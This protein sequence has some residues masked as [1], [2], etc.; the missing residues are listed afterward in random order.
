M[1]TSAAGASRRAALL[2]VPVLIAVACSSPRADE[3]ESAG[4][5]TDVATSA[6][7]PAAETAPSPDAVLVS[8][9]EEGLPFARFLEQAESRRR[10]WRENYEQGA[11]SAD[12]IARARALPGGLRLLVVAEDWCG[13]SA[14]TIPYLARLAEEAPGLDLRVIDSSVGRSMMEARPTPDGR[15]ATPTVV[16]LDE[17]GREV[18]CWV[19]RPAVL[20]EWFLENEDVLAEDDLYDQKYAWYAEDGGA[21]TV[22]DVLTVLEAAAAGRVVCGTE[23]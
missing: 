7:S 4:A 9:Y 14:N 19:E 11:P 13:D 15:A 17:S 21:H 8:L 1:S 5:T 18:G 12:A 6:P 22:G 16:V 3:G 2:L 10:T 20:Q 23:A